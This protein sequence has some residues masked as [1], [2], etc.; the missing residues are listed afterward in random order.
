MVWLG[1]SVPVYIE[2]ELGDS[3]VVT[4]KKLTN[5]VTPQEVPMRQFYFVHK[6]FVS[7]MEDCPKGKVE[8]K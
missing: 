4:V 3:Y 6:S 8:N 2:N 5:V 1:R 7:G